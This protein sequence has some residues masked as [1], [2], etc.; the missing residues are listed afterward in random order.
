[1]M[2]NKPC[3]TFK[4]MEKQIKIAAKLYSIRDTAK[5]FLGK[6]YQARIKPYKDLVH[7][8]MTEHKIDAVDD[9]CFCHN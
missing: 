2:E 7:L 9:V 3:K 1:M 4:I 5:K 8:V 6:D